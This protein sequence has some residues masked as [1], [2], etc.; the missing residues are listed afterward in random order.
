[1]RNTTLLKAL[2][3]L[4]AECDLAVQPGVAPSEDLKLSILIEQRQ[5]WLAGEFSWPFLQLDRE[6]GTVV[7]NSTERYGEFPTNLD[8]DRPFR[9]KA[10]FN[11][12][13]TDVEY[14]ITKDDYNAISSG[15]DSDAVLQDPIL[16]WGYRQ[17]TDDEFEVWPVPLD[18][19]QI[20]FIGQRKLTSLR[21][22]INAGFSYN[23]TATLD[24]D[25][26]LVVL[27]SAASFLLKINPKLA[28]EK[29][30]LAE[31]RLAKLRAAH[32]LGES[33][34]QIGRDHEDKGYRYW[35]PRVN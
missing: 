5:I 35:K 31:R 23:D 17:G 32:S 1:M 20:C 9:V 28:Q 6:E 30:A 13:W 19:S 8:V 29:L 2:Q 21:D 22:P 14:G 18:G 10:L 7:M 12:Y 24:L 15:D 16:K 33:S 26:Q 27:F 3:L 25:D 4:K 11:Q 34:F